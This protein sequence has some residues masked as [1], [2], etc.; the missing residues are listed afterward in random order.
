MLIATV[1]VAWDILAAETLSASFVRHRSPATI[2][3][4][5]GLTAHLF[6]IVPQQYDPL[7]RTFGYI[8]GKK[9]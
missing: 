7:C 8:R 4:W 1:V 5:T 2:L 3:A 6:G 9:T